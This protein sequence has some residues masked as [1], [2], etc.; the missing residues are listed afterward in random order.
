MKLNMVRTW[1][2]FEDHGRDSTAYN[3]KD[4]TAIMVKTED[5]IINIP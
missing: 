2:L 3:P 4:K 1:R 5:T